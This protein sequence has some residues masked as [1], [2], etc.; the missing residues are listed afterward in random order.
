MKPTITTYTGRAV[1]PL[2][3]RASD[4]CIEDIAHALA[5]TNRFCGHTKWPISVA[6]HSVY[7]SRLCSEG[8]IG[9]QGLLHDASEAYIGDVTK[10]LKASPE[11]QAYRAAEARLQRMIYRK[12]GCATR[13]HSYV[14][15]A[16][17]LMVRVEAFKS[18]PSHGMF[19][20]KNYPLPTRSELARVGSWGPWTW[21]QAEESFLQRFHE[22]TGEL[23]RG[24]A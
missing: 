24:V 1:N 16:D 19:R 5:L 20:L 13:Q 22:L 11:F 6:Q 3:L 23:D 9:L 7:V 21:R 12:F 18:N 14:D 17:Q 4:V 8:V 2:A 15:A 10:W